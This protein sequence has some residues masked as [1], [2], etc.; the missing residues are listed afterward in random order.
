MSPDSFFFSIALAS[1]PFKF[2]KSFRN[3]LFSI[4]IKNAGGILITI[5]LNLCRYFNNTNSSISYSINTGYIFTSLHLLPF[6]SVSYSFQCTDLSSPWLNLLL[7]F[8]YF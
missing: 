8:Y 5:A 6:L 4:S 2:P 1:Q 3:Y 7:S